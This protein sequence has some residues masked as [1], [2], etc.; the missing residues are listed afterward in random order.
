MIKRNVSI[1]L[2]YDDKGN[3]LFQNRKKISK[4]GEEY[5]FFGGKIE[6]GETPET[7]LKREMKEE[8][9]IDIKNFKLFKHY[10]EIHKEIDTDIHRWVFLAPMPDI[11]KLEVNEGE[12]AL[13][14][15]NK[16][17]NLKMVP[18]DKELLQEIKRKQKL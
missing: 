9:G 4:H 17:F 14:N 15:I 3:I 10:H 5:G 12:V 13:M 18:G 16:S 2:F 1:I 7:A 6:E 8:L 11:N